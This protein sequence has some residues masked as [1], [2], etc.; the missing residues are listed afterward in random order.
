[1]RLPDL[2][3]VDASSFVINGGPHGPGEIRNESKVLAG[4][5]PVALDAWCATFLD[6]DP[7]M[8][9][10]TDYA[11]KHKLGVADLSKID[12]REIELT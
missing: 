4:T 8:V 6:Y 5:D 3:I 12:I 11:A 10:S 9:A 1:M 7:G 2:T